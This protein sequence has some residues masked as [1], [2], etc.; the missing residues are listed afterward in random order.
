MSASGLATS[1][2]TW[3]GFGKAKEREL[4][5]MSELAAAKEASARV[6]EGPD[7]IKYAMNEGGRV[8]FALQAEPTA[9]DTHGTRTAHAR[10]THGTCKATHGTRT[11]HA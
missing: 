2:S 10:Y 5:D 1:V 9:R 11:A 7:A 4:G 3:F 8:D 6:E